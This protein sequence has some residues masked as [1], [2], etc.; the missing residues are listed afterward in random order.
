MSNIELDMSMLT[1]M[2]KI[3]LP[4]TGELKKLISPSIICSRKKNEISNI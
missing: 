4:S 1:S 2:V 3:S